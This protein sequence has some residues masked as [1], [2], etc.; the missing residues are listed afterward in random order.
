[1]TNDLLIYG[2]NICAFTHILGSPCSYMT[3]HPIPSEFSYIWR[4]FSFLFYQCMYR[5]MKWLGCKPGS[6]P[7]RC[8]VSK[9]PEFLCLLSVRV[10]GPAY[11][12]NRKIN[13]CFNLFLGN[14]MHLFV[15]TREIARI[16][17]IL[18]KF[19]IPG[20][21]LLAKL[22]DFDT[23]EVFCCKK[24][25][26]TLSCKKN[27]DVQ[28]ALQLA[29]HHAGLQSLPDYLQCLASLQGEIYH[30]QQG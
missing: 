29:T 8:I 13:F 25:T 3:L 5:T 26:N 15:V 30:S 7:F 4:K 6:S 23:L 21:I 17:K 18:F 22:S 28:R 20:I 2:E 12:K 1:M 27:I 14:W 11:M 16:C 19:T 24:R 9:I 10:L